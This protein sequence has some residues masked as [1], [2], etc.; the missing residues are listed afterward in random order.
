MKTVIAVTN[1]K[2]QEETM[3]YLF[4]MLNLEYITDYSVVVSKT[5]LSKI[6]VYHNVNGTS[7]LANSYRV[8]IIPVSLSYDSLKGLSPTTNINITR[9]LE[10][11]DNMKK[12]L[13][14]YV[15]ISRKAAKYDSKKKEDLLY[16]TAKSLFN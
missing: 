6:D 4:E 9:V 2:E 10:K 1:N 8:I 13:I 5:G 16:R 11:L 12:E 14:D 15:N 3:K 7:H